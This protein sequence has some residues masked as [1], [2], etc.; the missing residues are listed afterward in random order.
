MSN[1][2]EKCISSETVFHG[3]LIHLNRDRIE[4]PD[5]NRSV[6][7]YIRHPGAVG[8]IAQPEPD[9]LLLVR[10]YRY[11]LGRSMWEIPAGKLDAGEDPLQCAQR[12]LVEETGYS[13]TSWK[14]E[15]AFHSCVGYSDEKIVLFHATELQPGTA[16]PDPGEFLST[17]VMPLD[18]VDALLKNGGITDGKTIIAI[19][20]LTTRPV[21][22][23][24]G[25]E[26]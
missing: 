25:R 14:R 2:T 15:M 13:A 21:E 1:F 17:R 6:R 20:L 9:S 26:Y 7:E 18:Q 10:Q 16:R 3:K 12:E 22:N 19:L 23:A 4:L 11:P 8:I 24:S 5:G